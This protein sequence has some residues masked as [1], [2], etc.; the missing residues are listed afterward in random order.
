V[1]VVPVEAVTADEAVVKYK[2]NVDVPHHQD[3]KKYRGNG[4]KAPCT[5]WR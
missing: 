3:K 2:L 5:T 1:V 4:S